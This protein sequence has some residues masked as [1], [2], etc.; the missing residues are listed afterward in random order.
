MRLPLD[1]YSRLRLE[2]LS[3]GMH[4]GPILCNYL[5]QQGILI[6]TENALLMDDDRLR[7]ANAEKCALVH[8]LY[9][10]LLKVPKTS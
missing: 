9:L 1:I 6:I 7:F 8:K 5:L 4:N 2:E 10:T 3:D